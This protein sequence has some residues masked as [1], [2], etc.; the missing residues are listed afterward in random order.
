VYWFAIELDSLKYFDHSPVCIYLELRENDKYIKLLKKNS[1]ISAEFLNKYRR[2]NVEKVYI[3]S[4]DR[5]CFQ[6]KI[7]TILMQ[8]FGKR[9]KKSYSSFQSYEDIHKKTHAH[10]ASIG[11]SEASTNLAMASV[12]DLKKQFQMMRT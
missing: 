2:K 11:F 8:Y 5:D 9:E 4:T 6:E 3:V 7:E 10:L 1:P 12:A